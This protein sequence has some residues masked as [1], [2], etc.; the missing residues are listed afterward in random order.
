[1]THIEA[2][3]SCKWVNRITNFGQN[4]ENP[5]RSVLTLSIGDLSF[6]TE[7]RHYGL[8]PGEGT[9]DYI[10]RI[11]TTETFEEQREQLEKALIPYKNHCFDAV[12]VSVNDIWF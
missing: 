12:C 1:M 11:P 4:E 9:N 3:I 10:L 6:E 7:L 5:I 2:S 8:T